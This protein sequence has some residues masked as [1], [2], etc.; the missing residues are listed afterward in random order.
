[1]RGAPS[2]G[3][4]RRDGEAGR[5]SRRSLR[6]I[7]LFGM[8]AIGCVSGDLEPTPIRG[9]DFETTSEEHER[10][11]AAEKYHAAI[12]EA[13]L[14][15]EDPE[16]ESY[17][18][19]RLDELL[20]EV[21]M[22]RGAVRVAI[23][24][25]PYMN[26]AMLANGIMHLHTGILARIENEAQLVTLLGHELAHYHLRHGLKEIVYRGRE[27]SKVLWSRIALSVLLLPTGLSALPFAGIERD[28]LEAIV[29]P[30]MAGYSRD[31]ETEADRFGFRLMTESG[32]DPGES[33]R[34]F[35]LLIQ[36]D[37]A[38][39][40][41]INLEYG[42]T[43]KDPYYYASHPDLVDRLALYDGL[44][45]ALRE[46]CEA[47]ANDAVRDG[48]TRSGR[49]GCGS[50]GS[51]VGEERYMARIGNAVISSAQDSLRMGRRLGAIRVLERLVRFQPASAEAWALLGEIRSGR[52]SR[53]EDLSRAV[54]ELE[55]AVRLDP[56]LAKAHR[57]LGLLYR[58]LGR[59][60]EANAS[61]ARY[62]DV[63]PDAADRLI[64]EQLLR[65]SR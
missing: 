37:E 13:G 60:A 47:E 55:E 57:E 43:R 44:R 14:V 56:G 49:A 31:L 12:V 1:M 48:G 39:R 54:S 64:V 2:S 32:Y 9:A 27:K 24:K 15:L 22:D 45:R 63:L 61:F 26:A 5:R 35:D 34:F 7:V 11:R 65:E 29:A 42:H 23:I 52:G 33:S 18:Q 40:A 58:S 50:V 3:I 25:N 20:V 38:L 17:L 19:A 62:L 59:N 8:A 36:D 41:E 10:Q 51:K 4:E 53:K 21:G 28:G 16:L 30:Q 6:G 46:S